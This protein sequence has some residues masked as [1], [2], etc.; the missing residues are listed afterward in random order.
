MAD[1]LEDSDKSHIYW[2]LESYTKTE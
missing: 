2:K 1:R